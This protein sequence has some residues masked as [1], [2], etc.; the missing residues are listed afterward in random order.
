MSD[1]ALKP[2]WISIKVVA[3]VE[4]DSL[5]VNDYRCAGPKP[6]GGGAMKWEKNVR[7]TEFLQNIHAALREFH[8]SEA[9][10]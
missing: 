6:W 4:G 3:G 9:R 10:S 2:G 1:P 5:Y 7:A 8:L